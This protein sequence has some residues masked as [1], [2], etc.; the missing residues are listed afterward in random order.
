LNY[1]G[2]YAG[3]IRIELTFYDSRPRE[4]KDDAESVVSSRTESKPRVVKR[5]PLP[6]DPTN[7][8][9]TWH[10]P[11]PL[12]GT[13]SHSN[14]PPPILRGQEVPHIPNRQ[15]PE[16]VQ[17]QTQ[18]QPVNE[19]AKPEPIN[20]RI[21]QPQPGNERINQLQFGN[22]RI[23]QPQ[24]GNE[25]ISQPQPSNEKIQSEP[26]IH[27][28]IPYTPEKRQLP[29]IEQA[30]S[31][32]LP[33]Q[34]SESASYTPEKYHNFQPSVV[35][36]HEEIPYDE[37]KKSDL[38]TQSY[39][40]LELPELPPHTPR[41]NRSSAAPT[42]KYYTPVNSSPTYTLP[43]YERSPETHSSIRLPQYSNSPRVDPY[44]SS[45]LR[46]QAIDISPSRDRYHEDLDQK[47][48]QSPVP[49]PSRGRYDDHQLVPQSSISSSLRGRYDDH[50]SIIEPQY[51]EMYGNQDNEPPPPPPPHSRGSG[52]GGGPTSEIV[53]RQDFA[54]AP[55]NI[56]QKNNNT[57]S[58]LTREYQGQLEYGTSQ[59]TRLSTYSAPVTANHTPTHTSQTPM[60]TNHSHYPERRRSGNPEPFPAYDAYSQSPRPRSYAPNPQQYDY[61]RRN[62]DF[63]PQMNNQYGG[64]ENDVPYDRRPSDPYRD[65]QP[66]YANQPD[67]QQYQGRPHKESAPVKPR[68]ISP[69]ARAPTRKSVS[70]HPP[71]SQSSMRGVPFSPDSFDQLNPNLDSAKSI[72]I[73]NPKYD[74]PEGHREAMREREKQERLE[75][76]PIIDSTG[77]VI[78]PSDHLPSDTWAPEP[79]KKQP[80]KSHQI[81]VKFRHI[82]QGP[83]PRPIQV[84]TIREPTRPQSMVSPMPQPMPPAPPVSHSYSA[85]DVSP[86][87][88]RLQK[89][90]P[91]YNSS[92]NIPIAHGAPIQPLQEHPNYGYSH[93]SYHGRNSVSG[94]PIPAKIPYGSEQEDWQ[95]VSLSDEM[96]RIDIGPGSRARA[97]VR[98]G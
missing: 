36:E 78:D 57:G 4:E 89:R 83:Q 68:A 71:P 95:L 2:K 94:P 8:A 86:G 81:N 31:D 40:G 84:R 69:A 48:E 60:H 43:Q 67:W 74:T 20:E 46:S 55:L 17:P 15:E 97:P 23:S 56:R 73:P 13:N 44:Q 98:Y 10:G 6:T 93:S 59:D 76:G 52:G 42:P 16:I 38:A 3:E 50:N 49:P 61:E 63:R 35:D 19:R 27:S 24:L 41:T 72:N 51:G 54:P 5:R 33:Y 58:P 28:P 64:N 29:M 70:P 87:R 1:K 79:E 45:P 32:Y 96:S 7:Q 37:P 65:V 34:P 62:S 75:A 12:P 82:P 66:E 26:E 77:R 85:D 22:E 18:I 14:I 25:R 30:T 80:R 53:R 11:R 9:P 39:G 91:H 47:M 90:P 21:N 88:N 92:P